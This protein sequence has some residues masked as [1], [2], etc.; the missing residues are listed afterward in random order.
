VFEPDREQVFHALHPA[1]IHI[2]VHGLAG[3]ALEQAQEMEFAE[4]DNAGEMLKGD[5]IAPVC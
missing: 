5:A 1:L 2:L 4:A 3:V